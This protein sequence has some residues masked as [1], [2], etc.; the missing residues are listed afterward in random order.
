MISI[1]RV[2]TK[3]VNNDGQISQLHYREEGDIYKLVQFVMSGNQQQRPILSN[4]NGLYILH[5]AINTVSFMN[6]AKYVY[7]EDKV[8]QQEEWCLTSIVYDVTGKQGANSFEW[9]LLEYS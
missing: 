4:V 5:Y 1:D 9:A 2:S 7:N 8:H 6:G 3:S